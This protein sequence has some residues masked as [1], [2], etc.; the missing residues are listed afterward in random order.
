MT[1][2]FPTPTDWKSAA[3]WRNRGPEERL[4]HCKVPRRFLEHSEITNPKLATWVLDYQP[5]NSLFIQGKPG[6]GKST[7]AQAALQ[8]LVVDKPL[9]GRFVTADRY[10]EMLKDQFDNDNLL[11]EMYSSP[12]LIK[13]IQGVF[14]VVVLDGVGQ[15]RETDFSIHEVGSLIRRRYEDMRTTI[16]TT[17][18]GVTDFTRRY[19]ERVKSAVLDMPEIKVP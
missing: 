11:P 4:F 1:T 5:G 14:D 2:N 15:E 13:Y 12:Y 9:S 19:G 8:S 10:I 7:M 6:T 16:I 17:T 3:W 18:L